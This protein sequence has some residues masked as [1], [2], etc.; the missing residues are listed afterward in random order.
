VKK[1]TASKA[2]PKTLRA[3]EV[4]SKRAASVKGGREASQPSISEISITKTTD[5]SSG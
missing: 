1:K 4:T 2:R 3:K 5:R